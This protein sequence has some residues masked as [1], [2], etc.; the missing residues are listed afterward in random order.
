[1]VVSAPPAGAGAGVPLPLPRVPQPA[2]LPGASCGPSGHLPAVP[3]AVRFPARPKVRCR[4]RQGV[5]AAVAQRARRPGQ[6]HQGGHRRAA[7]P[8]DRKGQRRGQK[9]W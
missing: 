5:T 3:A 4:Q 6:A 2:A 9:Y 1:L 7:R 8:P